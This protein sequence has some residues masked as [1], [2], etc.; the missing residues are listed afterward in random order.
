MANTSF[1]E[2]FSTLPDPR[3]QRT[4]RHPLINIITIAICAVICGCNDFNAIEEFGKSK[5]DFFAKFLDLK[6]GIPSHDT[7]NDVINRLSPSAFQDSFIQ[8]V[9]RISNRVEGV[10]AIDGKSLRRTKDK[11]V[12]NSALHLVNAWSCE[13]QLC[14]GQLKVDAKTNEI[15]VI[16]LLL[17][18]LD[19]EGATVTI[20]AMGCQYSIADKI[21]DANANYIFALKGNKGELHDDVKLYLDTAF[22][23]LSHKSIFCDVNGDHGR[24]EQRTIM[25][26]SDVEWL[27]E[28]H[29]SWNSIETLI[30]IESI[31]EISGLIST[32]RRYYIT[33][34]K[35]KSA[36]CLLNQIRSHWQVE[37]CLHW[38]LDISFNEDN[39]RLRSGFA[40]ENISLM[41]KLAL[42]L[43]KHEKSVKKGI[44]TKRLKAGW[45]DNYLIKVLNT[46]IK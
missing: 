13:N 26:D 25:I 43:L 35:D 15:T 16:P 32:E 14:L 22:D 36:E 24:V 5:R 42:N 21:R 7:F 44:H 11:D 17:D 1:T 29:P 34:H 4:L 12:P 40:A 23:S 19:I 46:T 37:N 39:V 41:N 27:R 2:I 9:N 20:D 38:Q 31:R 33:S 45:D 8:W 18:L 10:I 6:N 30:L 28:R 3:T